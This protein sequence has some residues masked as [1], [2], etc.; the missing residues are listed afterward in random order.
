MDG[1]HQNIAQLDSMMEMQT[2]I[3][4]HVMANITLKLYSTFEIEEKNQQLN[5]KMLLD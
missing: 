5:V 2:N 1:F 3:L 4:K